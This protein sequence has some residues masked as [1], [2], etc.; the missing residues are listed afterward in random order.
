VLIALC[1]AM[2]GEAQDANLIR[3]VDDHYN[4]LRSLRARY[5]EHYSGMGMDRTESG[6]L[7]LRKPG[8]MRWSYDSPSGKLFVLDGRFAWFYTPGDAQV[9]RAPAKQLD[10]M[11]SP[12]RLLLGHTQLAKEL[13]NLTTAPDGASFRISGIP[14]GMAQRV[15]LLTLIVSAGGAIQRMKMEEIDGSTTEFT[16]SQMEENI[17]LPEANFVFSPP[18]GVPIVNAQPPI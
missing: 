10:D 16:F 2:R 7:M 8:L 14:K 6:T 11:R 5:V 3:R 18:H 13:D 4:H 9:S 1:S 12:L 17:P 15:K